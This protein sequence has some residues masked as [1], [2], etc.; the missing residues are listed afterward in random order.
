[1]SSPV[2]FSVYVNELFGILNSSG[3]GCKVAG[4]FLGCLGYA[5]DLLLLS[6]SISGLQAMVT[7]CERFAVSRGLK[8]STNVIIEKSKTKCIAFTSNKKKLSELSPV[9]LNGDPLPWVESIKHL[10][11]VLEADNS[12]KKDC[13][14]KRATFI[15]KLNSLIQ[16]FYFAAPEV[17]VKIVNIYATSF[18]GSGLWDLYSADCDRLYK[19][20]NVCIRIVF[21]LDRKAHRYL[22][23]PM[24]E[25][26]H[27]KVMLASRYVSFWGALKSSSKVCVRILASLNQYDQ[28]TVFGRTLKKIGNDCRLAMEEL[29]AVKV[30][31]LMHYF[32]TPDAEI[33]RIGILKELTD[34]KMQIAGFS[35][36]ELDH[37]KQFLCVS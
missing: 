33:W 37:I 30:K 16:E 22:I 31:Q 12:M 11:N 23:E 15:G 20:W 36:D 17:I 25:T 10:G 14:I 19:A 29:S 4:Q 9:K 26:L 28:R 32:P 1:M 8:F 18:Y 5:D 2:L 24:S 6:A 34:D 13:S 7:L 27:P 35:M 21:K 3:L